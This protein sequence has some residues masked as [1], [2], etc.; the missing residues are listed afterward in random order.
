[1]SLGEGF[2]VGPTEARAYWQVYG[3]AAFHQP[4]SCM[5]EPTRQR[6]PALGMDGRIVAEPEDISAA[7][8]G[9]VGTLIVSCIVLIKSVPR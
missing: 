3:P 7:P 5:G 8:L 2:F 9:R 4:I 6:L 1:M